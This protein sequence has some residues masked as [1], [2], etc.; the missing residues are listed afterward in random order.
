MRFTSKDLGSF[1]AYFKISLYLASGLKHANIWI[2]GNVQA[3]I[4]YA[5]PLVSTDQFGSLCAR[6][7]NLLQSWERAVTVLELQLHDD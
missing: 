7:E 1:G 6:F 2:P 5:G 4:W 3:V